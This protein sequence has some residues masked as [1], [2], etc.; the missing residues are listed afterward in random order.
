M[1]AVKRR[2]KKKQSSKARRKERNDNQLWF[3]NLTLYSCTAYNS[4]TKIKEDSKMKVEHKKRRGC[5]IPCAVV[6]LIIILAA[7]GSVITANRSSA[8]SS[9]DTVA[10]TAGISPA[11]T[12]EPE[13][14]THGVGDAGNLGD[15][16]ITL[17]AFEFTDRVDGDY[18]YCSPDEGCQYGLV[19]MSVTNSGT[20]ADIFLPSVYTSANVRAK[21]IYGEYEY[22]AT[23]L[24]VVSSDLHDETINPL[25]TISGVIAFNIP[26]SVAD[27]TDPLVLM[28]EEGTNTLEFTLR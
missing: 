6:L 23:N 17:D 5:L 19:S 12:S 20:S 7:V 2:R 14:I 1:F 18:A 25:V 13:A 10:A 26:D 9:E 3:C 15:W 11:A 27:S 16:G 21:I 22:S 4:V 24:L 28:L 8:T